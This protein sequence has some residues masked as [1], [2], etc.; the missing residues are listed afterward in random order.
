[1]EAIKQG[2]F[3]ILRYAEAYT[4][5][6][7]NVPIDWGMTLEEAMRLV[8]DLTPELPRLHIKAVK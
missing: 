5:L 8:S 3:T 6:L 7:N 4:V 2:Q 1:M